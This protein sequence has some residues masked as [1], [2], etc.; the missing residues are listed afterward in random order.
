MKRIG[1]LAV[2]TMLAVAGCGSN[3]P[4]S[5][6]KP[7]SVGAGSASASG[8][9][10]PSTSGS[11]SVAASDLIEFTVDGAGPYQLGTTLTAL[12]AKG[13]V[14]QVTPG[15]DNCPDNTTAR[16][17]GVWKDVQLSFHKDGKLYLLTNKSTSVPTPSGAWL[18]TPVAQLK[19]IYVGVQGQ[20][21]TQGS[22]SAFLVSTLS[23]RGIL[24]D[25]D[26]GKKVISMIAGDAAYLSTTYRTAG[27]H[28]C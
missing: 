20:D 2:V 28:F 7:P 22:G 18:G 19:T 8:S 24:F 25:L 10:S 23:G 11:P 5:T 15:G 4:A 17:T 6:A 9:A 16:G 14:D 13:S 26:P 12:Q 3:K 27:A 21:L 1:M